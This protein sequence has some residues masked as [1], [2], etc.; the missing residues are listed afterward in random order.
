MSKKTCTKVPVMKKNQQYI[1]WKKELQVWEAT[2]IV[3]GVDKK[4]QAGVLFESLEGIPRQT[5]LSELTVAEITDE[6]GVKNIIS[7]LDEFFIGNETQ[8]AYSSIDEVM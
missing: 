7:K 4:I 1:D 6:E 2:N 5:V 3:L 8:K